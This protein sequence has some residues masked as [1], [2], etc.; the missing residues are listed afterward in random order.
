[1]VE[2]DL[3]CDVLDMQHCSAQTRPACRADAGRLPAATAV[4]TQDSTA[5]AAQFCAAEVATPLGFRSLSSTAYAVPGKAF[6]GA[7]NL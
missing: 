5:T 7:T 6:P 2:R 3:T 1:M 4:Q